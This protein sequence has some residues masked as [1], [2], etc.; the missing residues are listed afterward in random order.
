MSMTVDERDQDAS[1]RIRE[2]ANRL[3]RMSDDL[4]WLADEVPDLRGRCALV[5]EHLLRPA[6]VR[7][8]DRARV[9]RLEAELLGGR[10]QAGGAG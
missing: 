6:I 5:G 1:R 4:R 10:Q 2:V 9:E 7:L 8:G 3:K